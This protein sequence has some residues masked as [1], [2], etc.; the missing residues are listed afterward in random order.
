M[1]TV[2]LRFLGC[3]DAF[4]SGG[5]FQSCILGRSETCLFLIDCGASSLITMRRHRINPDE[6]S[7]ILV[8]NFHGDHFGGCPISFWMPK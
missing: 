8:S 6:I 5:R 4:G 1:S 7:L 3:G 2:Q